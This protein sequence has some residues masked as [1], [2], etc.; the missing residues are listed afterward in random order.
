MNR[1]N[2]DET[3]GEV[4]D[5]HPIVQQDS[6]MAA[7]VSRAEIDQQI[8]TAKRFPRTVTQFKARLMNLATMD[9]ETAC[10]CFF[11]FPRSGKQIEGPSIRLAELAASAWQNLRVEGRM[12]GNDDKWAYAEGA[13]WDL[14]NNVAWKSPARR[15]ITKQTDDM[16]GLASAAAAAVAMRNAVLKV[17][18]RSFIQPVYEKCR[19]VAMGKAETLA[20][21]R[22][23]AFAWF[24]KLGVTAER[25]LLAL[26]RE[27]PDDITLE[28]IATL[29]GMVTALQEG[30]TT[31]EEA[32]PE[33]P[34]EMPDADGKKMGFGKKKKSKKS[35]KS[36]KADKPES[37]KEPE[38]PAEPEKTESGPESQ[39]EKERKRQLDELAAQQDAEDKGPGARQPD[40]DPPPPDDEPTPEQQADDLF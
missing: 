12:T 24:A 15:L 5:A 6:Q 26:G 37:P 29:A 8:A 2:V 38:K 36:K 27:G 16:I 32:F 1:D 28:D 30:H 9:Y 23:K 34:A 14:E 3:T 11:S 40:D 4:M 18:P 19:K 22:T 10:S 35:K 7:V 21:R 20:N 39:F 25:V 13:A 17:V 31:V 33:Q